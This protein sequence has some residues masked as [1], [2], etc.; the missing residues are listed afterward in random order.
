MTYRKYIACWMIA[1]VLALVLAPQ[2]IAVTRWMKASVDGD[3]CDTLN[4]WPG[5]AFSTTDSLVINEDSCTVDVWMSDSL[6]VQGFNHLANRTHNFTDSSNNLWTTSLRLDAAGGT[7][8]IWMTGTW[9]RPAQGL[10]YVYAGPTYITNDSLNV[11]SHTT[12]K[13]QTDVKLRFHNITTLGGAGTKDTIWAWPNYPSFYPG[14]IEGV[15]TKGAGAVDV[16]L[17]FQNINPV[18]RP[19]VIDNTEPLSGY[20]TIAVNYGGDT[21]FLPA[22][23]MNGNL[24]VSKS[25]GNATTYVWQE[26]NITISGDYLIPNGYSAYALDYNTQDHNLT[27]GGLFKPGGYNTNSKMYLYLNNSTLDIND[28]ATYN[29][30]TAKTIIYMQT[31][32]W[33]QSGNFLPLSCAKFVPG[34]STFNCDGTGQQIFC[35][36]TPD[37]Q[38]LY[39]LNVLNNTGSV[40]DT[41]AGGFRIDGDVNIDKTVRL[42]YGIQVAGDISMDTAGATADTFQIGDSLVI[43]S[44]TGQVHLGVG[45]VPQMTTCR[46]KPR[47]TNAGVIDDD[48]G[49]TMAGLDIGAGDTVTNSGAQISTYTGAGPLLTMNGGKLNNVTPIRFRLNA[50]GNF[51]TLTGT[52]TLTGGN[53][54]YY[55]QIAANN[56]TGTLPALAVTGDADVYFSTDASRTGCVFNHGGD[57]SCA[58]KIF[59]YL[60]GSTASGT[61]NTLGYDIT[62]AEYNYGANSSSGGATINFNPNTVITVNGAVNGTS[63]NLGTITIRDSSQSFTHTSYTALSAATYEAST[64]KHIV[65]GAATL[66]N[67]TKRWCGKLTVNASGATVA[68]ANRMTVDSLVLTAGT[69]TLAGAGDD[70]ITVF[71][72]NGGVADFQG[73][74]VWMRYFRGSAATDVLPNAASLLKIA[75]GGRI[76]LCPGDT[77]CKILPLGSLSIDSGG[78]YASMALA[79]GKTYTWQAGKTFTPLALAAADWSG[80]ASTTTKFVSSSPATQYTIAIPD[81]LTLSWMEPT[82]CAVTGYT[83]TATDGTSIDGGNNSGWVFG[84]PSGTTE[85]LDATWRRQTY[86]RGVYRLEPWRKKTWR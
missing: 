9:H 52:P 72:A 63:Y 73:D 33:N 58:D 32:T 78:S 66:T 21:I 8:T 23:T 16:R 4:W 5:G 14:I 11:V 29:G 80:S 35:S 15:F 38:H 18:K 84:S 77:M 83:I 48:I 30:S 26:G 65:N 40:K 60:T 46:L 25:A 81:A 82:D 57:V 61:F 70:S 47:T 2:G 44:A 64:A 42:C 1:C 7:D 59:E 27:V 79:D 13:F 50:T 86:N 68:S 49:W 39:D 67:N 19:L 36:L 76:A 71:Y 37:S 55:F 51:A 10:W 20:I 75:D 53:N 41:T 31:C 34:T 43:T 12:G 28:F 62:A 56:I 69:L 85:S 6:H 54:S 45:A 3:L 17:A 74:T 22:M 24:T